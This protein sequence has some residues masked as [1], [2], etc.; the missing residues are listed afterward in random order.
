MATSAP[1]TK[2]NRQF[3]ARYEDVEE[4]VRSENLE[5][6]PEAVD[7]VK[8]KEEL[9]T[10][11][12]RRKAIANTKYRIKI[13]EI[14]KKEKEEKER[15]KRE[16][17]TSTM[18]WFADEGMEEQDEESEEEELP[19][20]PSY[21]TI[22]GYRPSPHLVPNQYEPGEQG[23]CIICTSKGPVENDCDNCPEGTSIYSPTN[24][25]DDGYLIPPL[26][27]DNYD[28]VMPILDP[29]NL[30]TTETELQFF[31]ELVQQYAFQRFMNS[32]NNEIYP[33]YTTGTFV[34][35]RMALSRYLQINTIPELQS[36]LSLFFNQRFYNNEDRL[37]RVELFE[38]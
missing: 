31:W 21:V 15:L 37:V 16:E 23:E 34:R 3:P 25:P 14:K 2:I 5:P 4:N 32:K 36:R 9:D 1:R 12:K 13:K 7:L 27:L 8:Q 26:D 11:R 28:T 22:S 38:E 10:E 19:D 29:M 18:D 30:S 35:D 6:E 17:E 24:H 33:D 20:P